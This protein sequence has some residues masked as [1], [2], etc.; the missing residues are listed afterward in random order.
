MTLA[1][2][3]EALSQELS[4]E[5]GRGVIDKTGIQGRYDIALKRTPETGTDAASS[6]TDRSTSQSDAGP[7][8]FTAFNRLG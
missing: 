2:I 3:A 1:E 4:R 8:I 6:G 5:L 7:S